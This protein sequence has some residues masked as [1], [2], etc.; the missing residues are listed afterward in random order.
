MPL[1]AGLAIAVV[2][3]GIAHDHASGEYRIRRQEC[4]EAS[5]ALGVPSLRSL[6]VDDLPMHRGDFPLR[7]NAGLGTS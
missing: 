3:S 6:T 5:R 1:P 2:H 4:E 7:W